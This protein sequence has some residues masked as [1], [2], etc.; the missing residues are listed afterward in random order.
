MSRVVPGNLKS[1]LRVSVIAWSAVLITWAGSHTVHAQTLPDTYAEAEDAFAQRPLD[2]R[3]KL[4]VLLTA[5]GYWPAVPNEDFSPRIFDAIARFKRDNGLPEDGIVTSTTM[6]QLLAEAAPL[7][8]QWG[9][10]SVSLHGASIWVPFG[11]GLLQ[12]RTDQGLKYHD[13]G[14]R[15]S[16]AFHYYPRFT[17]QRSYDGLVQSL[18]EK[19]YKIEYSKVLSDDF[20]AISASDGEADTYIQYQQ[21]GEGGIGFDL[22]WRDDATD[23]HVERIATLV[24]GSLWSS[25]TAGASGYATL[26]DG[27]SARVRPFRIRTLRVGDYIAYNVF[28]ITTKA[29]GNYLLGQTFL[30]RFKSWSIDNEKKLLVLSGEEANKS[31]PFGDVVK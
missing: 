14:N 12:E 19:G 25:M 21:I 20:F 3:I 17:V 11:V 8:D 1:L 29:G 28:G 9:F 26:A 4:Q 2:E 27:S 24:S 13:R 5:A 16:L 6:D 23:L 22:Y 10:Q 31:D 18:R 7:L 30:R 15:L